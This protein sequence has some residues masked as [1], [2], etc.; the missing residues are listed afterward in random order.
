MK[1]HEDK[2]HK[3]SIQVKEFE[4]ISHGFFLSNNI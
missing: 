1:I 2:M 4:V 3:L